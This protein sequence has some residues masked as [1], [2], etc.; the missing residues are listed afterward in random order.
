MISCHPQSVFIR[1]KIIGD[2]SN[3]NGYISSVM[4]SPIVANYFSKQQTDAEDMSIEFPKVSNLIINYIK[5][6]K[7][8]KPESIK[9][10]KMTEF[11]EINSIN[12][13]K[14]QMDNQTQTQTQTEA[15]YLSEMKH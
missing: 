1:I 9:A 10:L 12:N 7:K 2:V 3:G 8:R 4:S 5:K 14:I 13:D 11:I 6:E 15:S